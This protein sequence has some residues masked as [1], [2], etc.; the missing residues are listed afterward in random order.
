VVPI[1]VVAPGDDPARA[2]ETLRGAAR[3]LDQTIDL[4]EML[5]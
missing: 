5:R 2:K 1:G 3:V 4:E